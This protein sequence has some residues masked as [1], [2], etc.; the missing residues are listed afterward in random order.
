MKKLVILFAAISIMLSLGH[1]VH[2]SLV[3]DTVTIERR[4]YDFYLG[5]RTVEV[6]ENIEILAPWQYWIFDFSDYSIQ[7]IS[8]TNIGYAFADF[9]GFVFTDL[10]F[11]SPYEVINYIAIDSDIAGLDSR[12][13]YSDHWFSLDFQGLGASNTSYVDIS[14]ETTLVPLPASLLLLLSSLA[15]L[16]LVRRKSA[17]KFY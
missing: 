13:S 12:L 16:F 5:S 17:K 9:N 6:T 3:G 8:T 4:F 15:A 10:D 11:G 2:A 7:M 14:L 1:G